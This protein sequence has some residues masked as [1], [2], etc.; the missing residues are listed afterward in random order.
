MWKNGKVSEAVLDRS[1]LRPLAMAGVLSGM[2]GAFGEDC[3][4]VDHQNGAEE[5]EIPGRIVSA[6]VCGTVGGTYDRTMGMMVLG[7]ANN[8]AASGAE[9][10]GI[11]LDIL[12]PET[13]D[14]QSLKALMQETAKICSAYQIPVGGGHT[15]I[16]EAVSRPVVC[17]TGFGTVFECTYLRTEDLKPNQDLVMSGWIGLAGTA[18]LARNMK[19]ELAKRYPPVLIDTAKEFETAL[20]VLEPARIGCTLG[21]SAMHDV[22]QGGVF[23]ALWE[24]SERAGVGLHVELKKI[25]VRQETIEI[26]NYFDINPYQMYGQGALLFGTDRGEALV[27]KLR[28]KGIPAAVIARTTQGNDR[29][30]RNGSEIRFLDRP[31]QDALWAL[32][33]GKGD[34]AGYEG[35]DFNLSGKKQ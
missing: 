12:I 4:F 22:S 11:M 10:N 29:V 6:T 31:A 3:A 9:M 1:V 5:G 32:K 16:S 2:G 20:S 18:I 33:K 8:L 34:S 17:V 7:A 25:P 19:Q 27:T 24:M 13:W 30:I 21:V 28:S 14:E 35:T 26:C 23:G 15:E